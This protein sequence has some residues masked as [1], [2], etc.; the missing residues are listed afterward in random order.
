MTKQDRTRI[1]K[2]LENY[3]KIL[4]GSGFARQQCGVNNDGMNQIRKDKDRLI[5]WEPQKSQSQ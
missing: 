2:H 3:I 1:A 5:E 4:E